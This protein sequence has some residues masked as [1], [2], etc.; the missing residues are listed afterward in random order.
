MAR[1]RVPTAAQDGPEDGPGPGTAVSCS[2]V[3]HLRP[4]HVVTHLDSSPLFYRSD[5][6]T[7]VTSTGQN[8]FVNKHTLRLQEVAH[9]KEFTLPSLCCFFTLE[10]LLWPKL[11]LN[12]YFV[13]LTLVL[14]FLLILTFIIDKTFVFLSDF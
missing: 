10:K 5:R 1:S 8:D 13:F 2:H 12:I 11:C 14:F 4:Q 9:E 7:Q 6:C 3:D